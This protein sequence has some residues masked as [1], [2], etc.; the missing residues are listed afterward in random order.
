MDV[1]IEQL[2]SVRRT[3]KDNL[4]LILIALGMFLLVAALLFVFLFLFRSPFI[5]AFI[6]LALYFSVK[7]LGMQSVEYEYIITNGILDIDKIKGKAK[8]ERL[9]SI[10]CSKI[11]AAGEYNI[12][13]HISASYNKK[14]VCC[15]AD[16][17]AY[18]IVASDKNNGK[19]CI[20]F[21]PNARLS[22]ALNKYVPRTVAHNLFKGE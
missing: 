4:K 11:D 13:T 21:A 18:Y 17:K 2:K 1:F 12:N 16:D 7:L 22:E 10:N 14:F 15:N 3:G 8:R 6:F 20:V 9:A 5:A 19:V